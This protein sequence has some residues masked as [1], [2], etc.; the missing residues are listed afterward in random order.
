[1][2]IQTFLLPEI[3]V[4]VR[5]HQPGNPKYALVFNG[6]SRAKPILELSFVRRWSF[7]RALLTFLYG[8]HGR[9]AIFFIRDSWPIFSV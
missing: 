5:C 2:L 6:T 4:G 3:R 7:I 8:R 9:A 1:M